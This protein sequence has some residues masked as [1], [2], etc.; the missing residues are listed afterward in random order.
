MHIGVMDEARKLVF[1]DLG[2]ARS[3]KLKV[4]V[5]E[6]QKEKEALLD[7]LIAPPKWV[8]P[9]M[10]VCYFV[11]LVLMSI[12][13]FFYLSALNKS[14]KFHTSMAI[15]SLLTIATYVQFAVTLY[16]CPVETTRTVSA[17][18]S[19]YYSGI[20]LI[21]N[22]RLCAYTRSIKPFASV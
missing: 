19:S 11:T 6:A 20:Y 1:V 14:W 13:M 4:C 12:P 22:N 10:L 18:A 9:S 7:R 17:D 8:F 21:R 3:T 2:S 16:F 15:Y 5:R